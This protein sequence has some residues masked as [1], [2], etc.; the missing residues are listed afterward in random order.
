ID[1][2][3]P[4]RMLKYGSVLLILSLFINTMATGLWML[5]LSQIFMGACVI[6]MA[7]SF[8]VL[9]SEGEKTERNESIKK[10]S[11]WMSGGGMLGPLIGGG[12]TS[13]FANALFG[14]KFS[15]GV[16][17]AASLL[18]F[19]VL[20]VTA[21]GY[22]NTSYDGAAHPKELLKIKGIADSY[23]SGFHLT[24][25][26]SVQFGLIG[27]FLIMYIQSLYMSF[28]P[29]YLNEL[30]YTT[31]LISIIISINGLAGMLSRYG[32]GWLMARTHMERILLIAG[33]T[34]AVCVV[35]T[36]IAGFHIAGVIIL[37]LVMGG[38]VG[39]N[40]PVSIM[41]VVNDTKDSDRGKIM[42]LRLIMNR[43]S[44]ILSPA[45]FG[46]LGQWFGLTIAF[47]A[48][49]GFLVATMLGFSAYTSM[50]WK[51]R[52]RGSDNKGT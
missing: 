4:I 40:L 21:R 14:Y 35:F 3:G 17:C 36:P 50:K 11:M 2:I 30:G 27:T 49:G 15:F 48:G 8:Q 9:V 33:L 46:V 51:L 7:S 6:I 31:L 19:I 42:G 25:I 22:R 52:T 26:R 37:V 13:L 45:M 39:I 10:Y 38:A 12:L 5:S 29:I 23:A 20:M 43:F 47:Y 1:S 28:M 24:K 34:A 32:L 41:I 16:A 44:Q 18:F